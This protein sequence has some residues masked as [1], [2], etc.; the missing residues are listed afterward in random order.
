MPAEVKTRNGRQARAPSQWCGTSRPA[1]VQRPLP[2]GLPVLP[3][4]PG[5]WR[6][7]NVAHG[8]RLDASAGA[9]A[10]TIKEWADRSPGG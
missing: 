1:P 3:L 2:P 9:G 10:E 6:A 4:A 7:A 5:P 8:N